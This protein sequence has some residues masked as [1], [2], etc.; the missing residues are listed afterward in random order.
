ME[1]EHINENT[2]RV[3]IESTDLEERGI[4]FL[5]LLGNH[6]QI[7]DF[8][9]SILEEVDVDE[10]FHESD[11]ITFQVL[12]SGNG[13]ELFI[14]KGGPLSEDIDFSSTSGNFEANEFSKL[15]K[16][17][18]MDDD[19]EK[20]EEN[21]LDDSSKPTQEV[22]LRF[23]EFEDMI[24]LSKQ[25]YL[26]SATS[27][28]YWYKNSYFLYMIFF[29]EETTERSVEDQITV[30]LEFTQRTPI[31]QGILMEHGRVI[32]ENNALELRDRKSVV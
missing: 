11:A 12:P 16:K 21:F 26:E 4:T 1:M 3:L 5:D 32:M 14:S 10:K 24:S 25:L 17:Q 22:V 15:I 13:L 6:K 20:E 18:L 19:E 23:N 9:Y 7:E 8:F 28:L 30:A 2:I 27:K 31:T 29:I